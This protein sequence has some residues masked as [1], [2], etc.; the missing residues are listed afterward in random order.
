[1]TNLTTVS[2]GLASLWRTAGELELEMQSLPDGIDAAEGRR[3]LLR[4]MA[5]SVDTF[6]EHGDTDC[7]AFEHAESPTRK[8]FADCPDTDYMRAPIS[9]ADGHTY[10]VWGKIPTGTL[11]LGVLLYGKGGRIGHRLTDEQLTLGPSGEFELQIGKEEQD[12]DWLRADGDET[13]VIV[14]QYYGDRQNEAPAELNIELVGK[15]PPPRPLADAALADSVA[16][17]ERMLRSIFKRTLQAQKMAKAGAVNQF[18]EIPGERLFPTPD[19]KYQAAWFQVDEGQRLIVSGTLP[20]TRYFGLTLYNA[21]LESLDYKR[22]RV[23]LNHRQ[24]KCTGDGHFEVCISN[25]DPSLANW[26]DAAGHRQGYVIARSL[27]PQGAPPL[28]KLTVQPASAS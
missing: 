21:W 25:E 27:L 8:M 4:M 7:P 28:L 12:G 24:L 16:R 5:A 10:R 17:A 22:H 20:T 15:Q 3:F 23:S 14:R 18:F 19:N 11:Y 2:E 1:M 26:L 13:A 6:V 9:M